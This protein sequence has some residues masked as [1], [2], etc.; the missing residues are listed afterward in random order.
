MAK[1][2]PTQVRGFNV[3][4]VDIGKYLANGWITSAQ[5]STE[6]AKWAT[7]GVNTVRAGF[8]IDSTPTNDANGWLADTADPTQVQPPTTVAAMC[9][10]AISGINALLPL[11]IA[12]GINLVV[13]IQNPLG[14]GAAK[15]SGL[16]WGDTDQLTLWSGSPTVPEGMLQW[17]NLCINY[18]T[19]N[20]SSNSAVVAYDVVNEPTPR[21]MALDSTLAAL[22]GTGGYCQQMYTTVRGS[23]TDTY[24]VIQPEDWDTPVAYLDKVFG[25]LEYL[26]AHPITWAD[27]KTVYSIHQYM[28][29]KFTSQYQTIS[30]VKATTYPGNIQMDDN[31]TI[32]WDANTLIQKIFSRIAAFKASTGLP[33]LLGEMGCSVIVSGREAWLADN[34]N[35]CERYGID[36]TVHQLFAPYDYNISWPSMAVGATVPPGVV[37]D[38]LDVLDH[39]TSGPTAGMLELVK[40]YSGAQSAQRLRAFVA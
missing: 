34:L 19:A 28:P 31:S 17:T 15:A 26:L 21:G 9:T 37:T 20:W 1:T 32:Y 11:L 27:A 7:W 22:Y 6:V 38:S 4:A 18:F 8:I 5:L 23:D 24:I 25:G 39:S 40:Q 16:G 10:L 36:W 2:W 3:S 35:L 29:R 13:S 14:W 12:N 33:F 30:Y